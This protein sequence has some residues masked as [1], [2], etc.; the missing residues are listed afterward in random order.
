MIVLNSLNDEGAGFG[1]D[2]NKTTF[3]FKD[4]R[5]V[6]QPLITK[7]E[8]ALKIIEAINSDLLN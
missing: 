6:A 8:T 5:T 4:G 1:V 2:T 3:I 7:D